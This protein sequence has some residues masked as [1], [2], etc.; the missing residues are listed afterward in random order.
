MLRCVDGQVAA[1][2]IP[3]VTGLEITAK[4][5]NPITPLPEGSA[6]LG[7]IFAKGGTP[8]Q[9]EATL[10]EAHSLLRIRIAPILPLTSLAPTSAA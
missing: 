7:F 3:G 10:R 6:Y 9:V 2:A 4:I 5:D 8:E 1:A